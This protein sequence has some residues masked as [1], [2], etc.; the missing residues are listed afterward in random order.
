MNK[1]LIPILIIF[2][3]V[4]VYSFSNPTQMGEN[5]KEETELSC[6]SHSDCP[7]IEDI[8]NF[9]GCFENK[10][11]IKPIGTCFAEKDCNGQPLVIIQCLG[12]WTCEKGSDAQSTSDS[13]RCNWQCT[14]G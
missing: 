3:A 12:Q 11:L 14:Q 2:L 8:N 9:N 6:S 4:V 10:C 7:K 5:V 1:I 13:G